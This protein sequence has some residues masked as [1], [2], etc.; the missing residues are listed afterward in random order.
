MRIFFRDWWRGWSDEDLA[1][2]LLKVQV[3][4]LNPGAIIPVTERELKAH[5]A[6]VQENYP[7]RYIDAADLVRNE[8]AQTDHH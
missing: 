2:V 4:G 5:K 7:L 8:N 6:Y 1:S 3:H